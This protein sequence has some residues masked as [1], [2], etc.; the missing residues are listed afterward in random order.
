LIKKLA[1]TSK[2]LIADQE[3]MYVDMKEASH[4]VIQ[5]NN[6]IFIDLGGIECLNS[7]ANPLLVQSL[8]L[9]FGSVTNQILKLSPFYANHDFNPSELQEQSLFNTYLKT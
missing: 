6:H 9:N 4:Y 8:T 3:K 1:A 5:I 2:K 7:S